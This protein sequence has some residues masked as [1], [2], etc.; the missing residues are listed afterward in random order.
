MINFYD[1]NTYFI[2]LL[3]L[4]IGSFLNVVIYRMPRELTISKGRSMCIHCKEQLKWFELFPLFSYLFLRGKCRHCKGKISVQ[5][6]L[7]EATTGIIFTLIYSYIMKH[8]GFLELYHILL[9]I[10]ATLAIV[11][12]FTDF[13][14]HGTFDFSTVWICVLYF[15]YLILATKSFIT[16]CKLLIQSFIYL[17]PIFCI[18][19]YISLKAKGKWILAI[20]TLLSI[21]FGSMFVLVNF[22]F[23]LYTS[24][25]IGNSIINWI[26]LSILLII[27]DYIINKLIKSNTIKNSISHILNSI[28]F[29]LYFLFIFNLNEN[30]LNISA[31]KNIFTF[32]TK[33]LIILGLF[34]LFY[35]FF[36]EIFNSHDNDEELIDNNEEIID[37]DENIFSSY[38][39]D[40]DLFILPFIGMILSYKNVFNFYAI[41][42]FS[43][44]SIY[45]IVFRKG[46]KY[47]IPL[48]PFIMLSIFVL[49]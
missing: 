23:D 20:I 40:G 12:I 35:M 37:R 18:V 46:F 16:P 13:L 21:V 1:I 33:N 36:I 28:N 7:V 30:M 11:G 4:L 29:I 41:L 6:P 39:G 2:F 9:F 15:V 10:I 25:L 31:F 38:I 8:H 44:L 5:Y 34:V 43:V 49:L 26:S 42:G 27:A 14:Y 32:N 48:Y 45:T 24:S 17:A 22:S 3:G 19:V 47:T